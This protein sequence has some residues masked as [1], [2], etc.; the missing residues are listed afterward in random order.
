MA[1]QRE[2]PLALVR[3]VC[4]P[5]VVSMLHAVPA[6]RECGLTP[7]FERETQWSLSFDD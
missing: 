2:L 7:W 1:I 6:C 4:G 5:Y 3:C